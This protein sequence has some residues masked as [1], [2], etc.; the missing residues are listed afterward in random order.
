MIDQPIEE[1]RLTL[2]RVLGGLERSSGSGDP[3]AGPK[4]CKNGQHC[5]KIIAP[6]DLVFADPIVAVSTKALR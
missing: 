5:S 1:A 6:A 4:G 3:D 2:D